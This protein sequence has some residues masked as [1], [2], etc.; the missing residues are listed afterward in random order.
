MY[1]NRIVYGTLWLLGVMILWKMPGFECRGLAMGTVVGYLPFIGLARFGI[2]PEHHY[3]LFTLLTMTLLSGGFVLLAAWAM[4][5]S[6]WFAIYCVFLALVVLAGFG[7][8]VSTRVDYETWKK[9][10]MNQQALALPKEKFHATRADYDRSIGIPF[11]IALGLV[12]LYLA[13]TAGGLFACGML[14]KRKLRPEDAKQEPGN[15]DATT[16]KS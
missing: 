12:G 16:E 7:Y 6:R 8:G 10:D 11:P 9:S 13:A 5:R 14:L 15:E 1:C 2:W 3:P 4:D